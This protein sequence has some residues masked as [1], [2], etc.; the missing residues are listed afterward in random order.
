MVSKII[1]FFFYHVHHLNQKQMMPPICEKSV[2][3]LQDF[4][5]QNFGKTVLFNTYVA[6]T[7]NLILFSSSFKLFQCHDCPVEAK[8]ADHEGTE[9]RA[10]IETDRR[11]TKIDKKN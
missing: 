5:L 3:I 7:R 1:Y 11:K 8:S 9:S 4:V 10:I 6:L 2:K